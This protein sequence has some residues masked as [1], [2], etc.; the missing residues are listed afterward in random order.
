MTDLEKLLAGRAIVDSHRNRPW[1]TETDEDHTASTLKMY[2]ELKDLGFDTVQDFEKFNSDMCFQ[3]YKSKTCL[4][5]HCDQCAG[6]EGTPFCVIRFGE[7]ACY[8]VHEKIL[9]DDIFKILYK[10]RKTQPEIITKTEN[11]T[12]FHPPLGCPDGHGFYVIDLDKRLPFAF[13]ID[14]KI[15]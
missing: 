1:Q 6:I 7:K 8:Y 10:A 13:D 3:E 14:W 2:S 15:K 9:L 11:R 12:G 5:G 4:E